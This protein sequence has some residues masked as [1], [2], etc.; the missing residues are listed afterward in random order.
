MKLL[1]CFWI[2]LPPVSL[3]SRRVKDEPIDVSLTHW[4]TQSPFA[5]DEKSFIVSAAVGFN[6]LTKGQL[7]LSNVRILGPG[8]CLCKKSCSHSWMFLKCTHAHAS[9]RARFMQPKQLST[10]SETV[11]ARQEIVSRPL[12]QNS[13]FL[14]RWALYLIFTQDVTACA[15]FCSRFVPPRMRRMP[16]LFPLKACRFSIPRWAA[17]AAAAAAALICHEPMTLMSLWWSAHVFV[18]SAGARLFVHVCPWTNSI[19]TPLIQ[20]FSGSWHSSGVDAHLHCSTTHG[21]KSFQWSGS[22]SVYGEVFDLIVSLP[23]MT[24]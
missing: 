22:R 8:S 7:F 11:S 5:Q 21:P 2:P 13:W 18:H 20:R 19:Q 16:T 4:H 12:L 10:C 15:Q 9:A 23:I 17:L 1:T 6:N 24:L 14:M 3:Q